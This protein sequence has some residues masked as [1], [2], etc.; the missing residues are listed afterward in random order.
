MSP[1]LM[2]SRRRRQERDDLVRAG[3]RVFSGAQGS[4]S[5]QIRPHVRLRTA[6][7]PPPARL[8]LA[9]TRGCPAA[10]P[11]RPLPAASAQWPRGIPANPPGM[12]QCQ[13]Q[14]GHPDPGCQPGPYFSY[15]SFKS[16]NATSPSFAVR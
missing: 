13:G 8:P 15:I 1:D 4:Q 2:P 7:G 10:E 16:F 9:G 5:P 12:S 6:V 11:K 14:W 3:K